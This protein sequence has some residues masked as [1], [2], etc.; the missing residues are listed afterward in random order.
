MNYSPS[1]APA[2]KRMRLFRRRRRL[3]RML[4]KLEIDPAEVKKLVARG[5]LNPAELHDLQ[6]ITDAANAFF[7][8]ALV[9]A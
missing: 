9:T 1:L 5:Y 8:D 7:S 3:Q 2:A 6:A 4:V